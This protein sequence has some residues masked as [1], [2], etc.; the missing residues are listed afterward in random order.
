MLCSKVLMCSIRICPVI[1]TLIALLLLKKIRQ[2]SL[3]VL[4]FMTSN[5]LLATLSMRGLRISKY[6]LMSKPGKVTPNCL[7]NLCGHLRLCGRFSAQP[8]RGKHGAKPT[9]VARNFCPAALVSDLEYQGSQERCSNRRMT[10]R[11]P[12]AK[13]QCESRRPRRASSKPFSHS[14]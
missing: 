14:R 2:H 9:S 7:G 8:R 13:Y 4:T 1:F 10:D 3:I 12:R 5:T 6:L 11:S